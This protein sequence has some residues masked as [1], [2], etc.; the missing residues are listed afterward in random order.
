MQGVNSS[1]RAWVT[2]VGHLIHT[3]P[4]LRGVLWTRGARLNGQSCTWGPNPLPFARMS[5][6]GAQFLDSGPVCPFLNY[7]QACV[8]QN[9]VT[10][11]V[12]ISMINAMCV[13]SGF[14]AK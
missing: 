10:A 6:P 8:F 7:S 9:R 14:V 12:N 5:Q 13:R 2:S 4:R 11:R 3:H 1:D